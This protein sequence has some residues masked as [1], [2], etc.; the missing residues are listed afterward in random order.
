MHRLVYGKH[1]KWQVISSNNERWR[2]SR[3]RNK[4]LRIFELIQQQQPIN[5]NMR[6]KWA[7]FEINPTL[8]MKTKKMLWFLDKNICAAE[9]GEPM[10]GGRC[11]EMV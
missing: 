10:D 5:S 3:E 9:A 4:I 8:L 11:S 6:C 1:S 2:F 7:M